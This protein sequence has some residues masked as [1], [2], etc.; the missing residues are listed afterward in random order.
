MSIGLW[1][2]V[3]LLTCIILL[4]WFR[5]FS[6][7][8]TA[9]EIEREFAQ[10]LM[11]ETNTLIDVPYRDKTMRNLADGINHQLRKLREERHKFQQGDSELKNAVTNISHD[12]RTPLTAICGYLDLLKEEEK[13]EAAAR[14]LEQIEDRTEAL[15]QLT[16]ELFKYSVIAS[17]D[18]IAPASIDLRQALEESLLSFYG[19][20]KQKGLD[21]EISIT[22]KKVERFLD[23]QGL[24]RVFS[25]IINNAIKYSDGD[26]QVWMGDDGT[27]TFANTAADLDSVSVAKLFDRFY[28]VETGRNSTGLGLSIAK[29]L[30]ERMGGRIYAE[31]K[32]NMLMITVSFP[33]SSN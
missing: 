26:F 12:L 7:K 9:K 23:P 13:S 16:E 21:T 3:G 5:L 33:Q 20:I 25:N 19:V 32:E 17:T 24:S 29:L 31:Y 22:E 2:L 18:E 4:L 10:R 1:A 11:T 30:T 27:I 15:K 28:T 8:K 6:I 14:Y